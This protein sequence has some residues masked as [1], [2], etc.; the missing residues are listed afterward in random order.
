M[1]RLRV[2]RTLGW[3]LAVASA[4]AGCSKN[5]AESAGGSD[6]RGARFIEF[7][8]GANFGE[9]FLRS[10]PG[11]HSFPS[12]ARI[13]FGKARGRVVIPEGKSVELVLDPTLLVAALEAWEGGAVSA[14]DLTQNACADADLK[15]VAKLTALRE[16]R[17]TGAA[18][19]GKGLSDLTELQRLETLVLRRTMV[20]DDGV[21]RLTPLASLRRLDLHGTRVTDASIEALIELKGL[22]DLDLSD[23][24]VTAEGI[25]RLRSA[26]PA[27]KIVAPFIPPEAE[28]SL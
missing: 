3:A 16:L 23:T 10:D 18:I 7:P 27:A 17:L 13:P 24:R 5:A 26:L 4:A 6:A 12:A 11:L 21:R 28:E 2:R 9:L 8:A 20:D 15:S 14:L 25:E 22:T 19:E 1:R